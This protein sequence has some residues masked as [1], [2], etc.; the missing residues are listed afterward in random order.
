VAAAV[1]AIRR[2]PRFSQQYV[3][4]ENLLDVTDFRVSRALIQAS[5][6]ITRE[7]AAAAPRLHLV[8]TDA[9]YGMI[10]MLELYANAAPIRSGLP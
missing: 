10:R 5:A 2:D 4:I 9:I 7:G 1:V 6:Q 3:R 8:G